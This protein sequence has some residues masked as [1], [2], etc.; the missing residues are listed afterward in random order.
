MSISKNKVI[1]ITLGDPSG[2]GPEIIAKALKKKSIAKLAKFIIIGDYAIFKKHITR[3]PKNCDFIDLKQI[4]LSKIKI[5]TINSISG[6]A[7]LMYLKKSVNLIKNKQINALVTGPICKEA[8]KMHLSSFQGHTEFL[9]DAAGIK[10]VG[11][12]F[13]ADNFKLIIATR[14]L[15]LKEISKNFSTQLVQDAIELTH[16][17]LKK[18]FKHR[19]PTLGILGLNPHAGEGGNMGDEE[20]KYIIPAIKHAN[21]KGIKALG[22][23]PADTLF[24][25]D[26]TNK[27][28]AVVAMYHDQGL[29]PIKTLYFNKLVNMTIGLPY[30]RTSPAHGTAFDIAKK[31]IADETPMCEAI[32]LAVQLS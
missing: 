23:F 19:N 13:V 14:H 22:P 10:K 31:N 21:K 7:S 8:V 26:F 16:M 30:I 4:S 29:I 12:L 25:F 9:A 2:I 18:H 1:G 17:A 27:Y 15:P 28:N 11:M 20:I 5:G 32:K 3:L 24:S 6:K